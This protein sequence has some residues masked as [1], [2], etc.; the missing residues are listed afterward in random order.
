MGKQGCPTLGREEHS[1]VLERDFTV[2]WAQYLSFPSISQTLT[3]GFRI[4]S[5]GITMTE[6][7]RQ[8]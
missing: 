1:M 3:L 6:K 5:S 2:C 4:S 7:I 8:H